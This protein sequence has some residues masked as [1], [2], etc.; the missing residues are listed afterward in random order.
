MWTTIMEVL[1]SLEK[2]KEVVDSVLQGSVGLYVLDGTNVTFS[3]PQLLV[4]RVENDVHQ[5]SYFCPC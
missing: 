5:V 1:T 3:V 4:H 2:E